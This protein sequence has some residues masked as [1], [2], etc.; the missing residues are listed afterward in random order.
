MA[1]RK[2]V[3][4]AQIVFFKETM[5]IDRLL[6]S[7]FPEE[8]AID[9][10]GARRFLFSAFSY[11]GWNCVRGRFLVVAHLRYRLSRH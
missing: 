4:H 10:G 1:A 11:V 3:T 7:D 9:Y 8:N 6:P 5:D 2:K